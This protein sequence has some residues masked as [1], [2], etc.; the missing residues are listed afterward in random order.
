MNNRSGKL[1]LTG[2]LFLVSIVNLFA[3]DQN[4]PAIICIRPSATTDAG[5]MEPR[6]NPIVTC[7]D[8]TA[9]IK[10][11]SNFSYMI[12]N[13]FGVVVEN[14]RGKHPRCVG[15]NL[16]PGIYS[17]SVKSTLGLFTGNIEIR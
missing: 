5:I 16:R 11:E 6:D 13:G 14:G 1:L 17:L 3:R 10:L 8:G 2:C 7:K 12:T 15:N 4:C 9:H